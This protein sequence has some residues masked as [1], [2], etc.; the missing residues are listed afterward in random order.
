MKISPKTRSKSRTLQK[1]SK[2][3]DNLAEDGWAA[4]LYAVKEQEVLYVNKVLKQWEEYEIGGRF[5][6]QALQGILA[7]ATEKGSFKGSLP[8]FVDSELNYEIRALELDEQCVMV[9]FAHKSSGRNSRVHALL[10]SCDKEDRLIC[11][12]SIAEDFIDEKIMQAFIGKS[13]L[14]LFDVA[15]RMSVHKMLELPPKQGESFH[16]EARF[17]KALKW[18][19]RVQVQK[20]SL[21][22]HEEAY[23][24]VI[25]FMD[26]HLEE[27]LAQEQ[28]RANLAEDINQVL[29]MEIAEHRRTQDKLKA[30]EAYASSIIDSSMN[31]IISLDDS[32]HI[33]EFNRTAEKVTGYSKEEMEAKNIS[34]LLC[35]N[36]VDQIFEAVRKNGIW[37]GVVEGQK[38]N[39]DKY[40]AE[41]SLSKLRN[42]D[43]IVEGFL[44]SMRDISDM[45]AAERKAKDQEEKISAIFNSGSIIFWTVNSNTALTSF[46][47]AYKKAVYE[48]YGSYPEINKDLNKPKK[49]FASDTYHAFWTKKYNAVLSRGERINF[50]TRTENQKGE[51]HYRDIY[52]SPIF[53]SSTG[54]VKEVAGM[55]IDITDKR[56]TER[57]MTEQSAKIKAI[58]NAS[59]HMIWSVDE[60]LN[61]TSFNEEFEKR[62]SERHDSRPQL[63]QSSLEFY[64]KC[65]KGSAKNWKNKYQKIL[66][67]EKLQFELSTVDC[68][69]KGHL[70]EVFLSPILNEEGKVVEI[71]GL[72]QTVTFKRAAEQKL[73]EQAA[74]ISA[75]FDSTAM[76]IWTVDHQL[77]IVA[78]NKVF[79]KE[80]YHIL[81]KEVSIGSDFV[82]G[83]GSAVNSDQLLRLRE[84]FKKAFDGE[85]QQFEG[86]L[87]D[88]FGQK[89]WM[90]T[91]LN[92][93]YL[94]SGKIKEISCLSY[95]IT[96]KKEIHHQMMESI[97]EKEILLQEVHHRVKNNLQVISS[98]LNLQSSY[99]KDENSL[100]ILRESQNRIK[101]MSFIH[102]SLYHT[103]D[104]S[105]IEFSDYIKA[106]TSNLI[107]SYSIGMSTIQLKT[108]FTQVYL[109]LDQAIPCGLM[110]NELIS[111][112]LKYAFPNDQNG[113]IQLSLKEK[114]D[115]IHLGISDNGVGLPE[116]LDVENSESLGLQLVYTLADQLEADIKVTSEKGTNYLITFEKD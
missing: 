90:E 106:L 103:R 52:L 80:H 86:V 9:K 101:S 18:P 82:K 60:Q 85:K 69:G 56:L 65:R 42:R 47:E 21:P 73:K 39:G 36:Y 54:K 46:N 33:M 108:D 67:G 17:Q 32:L 100:K 95:D 61:F 98:I 114:D 13:V 87:T 31:M 89:R 44:C 8:L 27:A 116:D 72:A 78:Y 40:A 111:N 28:T 1:W 113:E 71:A 23:H 49:K 2:Y 24:L 29:K 79:G 6:P 105:R 66:M 62:M 91:F 48:T 83:L 74:K 25:H 57:K 45:E 109:S 41:L 68:K 38:K 3:C 107:H 58:F 55:A 43:S 102:E 30:A 99:V 75:I 59:H 63:G 20:A 92:P 51:V 96:D 110:V 112:A 19:E 16:T 53:D 84:F 76:L 11:I 35:Q 50:Q 34:N 26:V 115:R 70:E 10:L 81:G 12:N 7:E 5:D 15:S 77:R 64:E 94:E 37:E 104:F 88:R 97:H 93:I 4:L 14:E 22:G